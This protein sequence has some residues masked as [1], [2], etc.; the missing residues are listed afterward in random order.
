M[1]KIVQGPDVKKIREQVYSLV[2][3]DHASSILDLG[4]GF[5]ND[6]FSLGQRCGP[7]ARL[8]GID[9][10]FKPIEKAREKTQNDPRFAFIHK[11]IE[12]GLPFEDESF[13]VVWSCNLL[14]CIKDKDAL[15]SEVS[16]VLK[17]DGQV[18]FS[19]IDWDTQVINGTDKQLIR[20]MVA[21]FSD[22]TQGWMSVSDGWMGR[23]M[24]GLFRNYE[25]F[26]GEV[27]PLVLVN[28]NYTPGLYGYDRIRDFQT[29]AEEGLV[30]EEDLASFQKDLERTVS[31]NNYF[32]SVTMY[33]FNGGKVRHSDKS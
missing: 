10:A 13:D 25:D 19:H 31:E 29:M 3:L 23:R 27:I 15:L 17:P 32:Y 5:G 9:S 21:A 1:P 22:W 6:L 8:T 28:E 26:S 4:C 16:R 20:K 14:E 7:D 33:V 24:T 11:D 2:S 12:S 18:V 30:S